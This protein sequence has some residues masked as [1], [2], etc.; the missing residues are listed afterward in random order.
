MC[1]GYMKFMKVGLMSVHNALVDLTGAG[2]SKKITLGSRNT[3]KLTAEQLAI[4]TDEGW[5]LG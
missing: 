5:V 3:S 2:L 4:T 1:Y